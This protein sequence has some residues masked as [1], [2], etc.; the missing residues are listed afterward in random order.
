MRYRPLVDAARARCSRLVTLSSAL[1]P[2]AQPAAGLALA[3]A[4]MR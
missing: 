4:G 2:L 1:P 3:A